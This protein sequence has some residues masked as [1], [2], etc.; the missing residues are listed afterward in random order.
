MSVQQIRS[1]V[2]HCKHSKFDVYIGR[3]SAGAPKSSASEFSWGNPFPMRNQSSAERHRVTEEYR[4]FLYSDPDL[5][6]RARREL[7]GKVLACWCSPKV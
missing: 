6:A 5:V 3:Q 4:K 1:L 2:V 7:K